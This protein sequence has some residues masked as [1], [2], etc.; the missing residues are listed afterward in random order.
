MKRLAVIG[1]GSWGSRVA[2]EAVLLL[3]E[4]AVDSVALC[5]MDKKK[6]ENFKKSNSEIL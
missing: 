6:I 1:M 3:K 4:G 5:D 2:R